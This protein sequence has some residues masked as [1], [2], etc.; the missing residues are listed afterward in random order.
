MMAVSAFH[1]VSSVPALKVSISFTRV[2]AIIVG[3]KFSRM[4]SGMIM[5]NTIMAMVM[6]TTTIPRLHNWIIKESKTKETI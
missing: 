5:K 3:M 4:I 2:I 6:I 1:A